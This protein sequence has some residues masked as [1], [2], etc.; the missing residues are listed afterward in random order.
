[1]AQQL[2]DK[3]IKL[4]KKTLAKTMK[5]IDF[6]MLTTLQSNGQ[7]NSRPMS[8]NRNVDWD[9]NTWFFAFKDSSQVR[10]TQRHSNVNLSY[11]VPDQV[12]F[13]SLKGRGE[14]VTDVE[15]KKELWYDDL[16]RWFPDGPEDESVVLIKVVGEYLEYW[17]K[18]GDGSLDL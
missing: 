15:K 11:A 3:P 6:C 17:G 4:D 2:Q 12:M 9:G 10:E 8:N 1:M 5:K 7:L 16:G 13:I 14:I 18:E